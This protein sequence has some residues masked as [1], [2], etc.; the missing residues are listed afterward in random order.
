MSKLKQEVLEGMVG[1]W[2][3]SQEIRWMAHVDTSVK[4]STCMIYK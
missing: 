1:I 2:L 4:A 3:I